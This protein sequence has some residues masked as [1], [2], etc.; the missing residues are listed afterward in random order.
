MSQNH[1]QHWFLLRGLGRDSSHWGDFPALFQKAMPRAQVHCLDLPG[2]GSRFNEPS[3][4]RLKQAAES[5]RAEFLQI[6][7]RRKIPAEAPKFVLGIS[8]GG[9]VTLHW[10]AQHAQDFRGAVL[11]NPSLRGVSPWY[12]R[13]SP[14]GYVK[15]FQ[16]L[17]ASDPV[18]R[19]GYVL[20]LT[21]QNKSWT[22]ADIKRR[23]QST[24][25]KPVSY[26]NFFR[27][28]VAAAT[29]LPPTRKPP[30]PTLLLN[31]LG[32]EMVHPDCS[33][34]IK[35]KWDV[36]LKR[37]AWAGHDLPL[38]DPN[39]TI[40]AVRSWCLNNKFEFA[41]LQKVANQFNDE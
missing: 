39:W 22:L 41:P 37:H 40:E 20:Q 17:L 23:V 1:P 5:A 25:K 13:L 2:T 10:L 29:D 7:E 27:Q 32:D 34:D 33:M 16:A 36:E 8:L 14:Q 38:D 21:S 31:S 11:I 19:E 9:M 15:L 30:V 4:W 26:Q 6:I 18:A 35:K 28:L 12:Q 3:P 24:S